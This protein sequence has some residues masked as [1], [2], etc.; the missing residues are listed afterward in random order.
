MKKNKENKFYVYVYL[1]PRKQGNYNY[2]QYHFDYEP[3]YVG[4]G[5]RYRAVSHLYLCHL[6]KDENRYK[7]NRIKKIIR[8]GY[9][10]KK[11]IKLIK[12]GINDEEALKTEIEC[13]KTIGRKYIGSKL[14]KLGPLLNLNDGGDGGSNK[15]DWNK[16]RRLNMGLSKL[17][18]DIDLCCEIL[19]KYYSGNLSALKL[20]KLFN[21]SEML[22]LNIAKGKQI[23]LMNNEKFKK[24]YNEFAT[25]TPKERRKN[26]ISNKLITINDKDIL[27][28]F[29]LFCKQKLTINEISKEINIEMQKIERIISGKT[30]YTN[31]KFTKRVNLSILEKERRKLKNIPIYKK[32]E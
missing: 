32:L 20:S 2:G 25:F 22:V 7:V 12:I 19:I 10:I 31:N 21:I 11:Y 9:D 27:R 29:D 13:I 17:K 16:K 4:K 14:L 24:I 3:F 23:S 1:D 5:C 8:E 28:I 18:L 15:K 6:K 30:L 26:T